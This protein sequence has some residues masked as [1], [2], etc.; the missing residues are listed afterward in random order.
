MNKINKCPDGKILNPLTNRCVLINGK[1]GK[2]ILKQQTSKNVKDIIYD[3]QKNA[4][5]VA[6]KIKLMIKNKVNTSQFY[7]K[8]LNTN[9]SDLFDEEL[10]K[11][12]SSSAKLENSYMSYMLNAYKLKI[13]DKKTYIIVTYYGDNDTS[14]RIGETKFVIAIFTNKKKA[15]EYYNNEEEDDDD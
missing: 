9:D 2:Q 14:T 10:I 1:I 6:N 8:N 11:L 5:K 12:I 15:E 13:I 4:K 3:Y 7:I